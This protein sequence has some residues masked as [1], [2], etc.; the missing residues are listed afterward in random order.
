MTVISDSR[1]FLWENLNRRVTSS[2]PAPGVLRA[3]VGMTKLRSAHL[4]VTLQ[5]G[6]T[7]FSIPRSDLYPVAKPFPKEALGQQGTGSLNQTCFAFQISKQP[8]E[9]LGS[10]SKVL[11]LFNTQAVAKQRIFCSNK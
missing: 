7:L 9:V 3:K 5:I 6:C 11:N 4:Q 8:S 10:T 1:G 2:W